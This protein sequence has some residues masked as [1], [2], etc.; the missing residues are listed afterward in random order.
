MPGHRPDLI[1]KSLRS[2][3]DAVVVDLEDAVAP[4][5]RPAARVAVRA[6]LAA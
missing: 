4:A 6:A 1:A 3:A 5:D 2:A